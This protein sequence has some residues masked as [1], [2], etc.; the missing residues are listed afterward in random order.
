MKILE[1]RA[2][3]IVLMVALIAAG[4]ILGGY[5]SLNSLYEKNILNIFCRGEDNDG[6]CIDNDLSERASD[7]INMA[8]IGSK[9]DNAAKEARDA[10]SAAARLQS[11]TDIKDKSDAN[12]DLEAAV[13]ALFTALTGGELSPSDAAYVQRLYTDF[14]SRNET[15]SHDPYNKYALEYNSTIGKFPASLIPAKEAEIFY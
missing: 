7:A 3:A 15:I 9:Y 8:K 4:F 13:G 1:N 5:K 14:N 11:M 6:V 2:I 12:K 10:N